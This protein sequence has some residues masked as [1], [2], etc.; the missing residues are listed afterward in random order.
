MPRSPNA[1]HATTA[2]TEYPSREFVGDIGLE[3]FGDGDI[4]R[5]AGDIAT[6]NLGNA[7]PEVRGGLPGLIRNAAS[8]SAMAIRLADLE[9]DEAA[10]VQGVGT[11]RLDREGH[12][13]RVA[14]S[15]DRPQWR[16]PSN[17]CWTLPRLSA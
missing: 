13:N 14:R 16:A 1:A 7:S 10:S 4:P 8:Q 17:G 15:G 3:G 6:F 9:I 2:A 11:T 12:C 5:S